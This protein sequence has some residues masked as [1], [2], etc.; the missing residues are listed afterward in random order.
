[1]LLLVYLAAGAAMFTLWEDG[2]DFFDGFYFCFITMTTIGFGDL[3]PRHPSYTLLCTLYILVGLA[4]TSTI[5]E[6]VR[7][8]YASSWRRLQEA[9]AESGMGPALGEALRRIPGDMRGIPKG[10]L[11]AVSLARLVP[12]GGARADAGPTPSAEAA[13]AAA[14][15]AQREWEEAVA[16]V[17]REMEEKAKKARE[18]ELEREKEKKRKEREKERQRRRAKRNAEVIEIIVYETTV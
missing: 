4:L 2:W 15:R 12:Q 3:V 10:I 16:A 17:L 1:M 9:L 6:L 11:A 14:T 18:V 8:Q 7:R 5:I 13:E